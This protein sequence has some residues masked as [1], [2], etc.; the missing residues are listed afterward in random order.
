MGANSRGW[1]RI[2]RERLDLDMAGRRHRAGDRGRRRRAVSSAR[3]PRSI[4]GAV[5]AVRRIAAD[6]PV[7]IASSAHRR[8]H[9]R[10]ARRDRPGR[11]VRG[12]GLVGRG[13]AR[14][15]GAGRLSRGRAPAR[16]RPG[17]LRS[18]SRTRATGS[19]AGKAAGMTVVLVPNRACRRR[20]GPRRPRTSSSHRLADLD[21]DAVIAGMSEPGRAP[22]GVSPR[23]AGRS[24]TTCR[25][26]SSRVRDDRGL[27]SGRASRAASGCPAGPAIYCFNHMS[28]STRS[29]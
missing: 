21:P 25:A 27:A 5:E 16:R 6:R 15:A 8:G 4:D 26:W 11:D 17:A 13:R 18:W 7:A 9:R 1:S 29:C 28:W 14:Q 22:P 2:M 3:A 19:L 10:R 24:A 12:R 23:S 20:R